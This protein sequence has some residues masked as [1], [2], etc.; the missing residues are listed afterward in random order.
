LKAQNVKIAHY[1]IRNMFPLHP[2]L[3]ETLKQYKKVIVAEKNNGQLVK[4]IRE[5]YLI[6][7]IPLLKI[8]GIPFMV[9]E[10][11]EFVKGV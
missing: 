1:H 6:D 3:G 4:I 5:K 11:V 10:V 2:E 9:E 7:C 8:Q